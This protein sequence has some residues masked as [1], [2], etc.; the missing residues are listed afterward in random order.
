MLFHAC[1]PGGGHQLIHVGVDHVA[2]RPVRQPKSVLTLVD[3]LGV[4]LKG[5]AP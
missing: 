2:L 5:S 3:G 4:R 1:F